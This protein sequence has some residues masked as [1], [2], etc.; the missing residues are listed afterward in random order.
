MAQMGLK[1][2]TPNVKVPDSRM[3]GAFEMIPAASVTR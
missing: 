2:K 1:K 3:F